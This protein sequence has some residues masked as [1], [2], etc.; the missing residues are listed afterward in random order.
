MGEQ[1][2]V[3]VTVDPEE[4]KR[5]ADWHADHHHHGPAHVLYQAAR[6]A[7]SVGEQAIR[8]AGQ[9]GA[10][11]GWEEGFQAGWE[12]CRDPGAF[13]NDYWD[14]DTPNPYREEKP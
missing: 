11:R 13:V 1:I 10:E 5:W 7:E 2:Q 6:E 9:R 8:E 4:L 12:E 14:A 3:K